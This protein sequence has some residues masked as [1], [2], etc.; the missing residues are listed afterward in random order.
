ME[1]L[2]IL[3]GFVQKLGHPITSK[4]RRGLEVEVEASQKFY[5]TAH[6]CHFHGWKVVSLLVRFSTVLAKMN[7]SQGGT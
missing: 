4:V 2:F 7:G 6:R 3:V 5:S 1:V